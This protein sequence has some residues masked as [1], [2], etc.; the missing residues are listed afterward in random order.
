MKLRFVPLMAT[1]V[2]ISLLVVMPVV[3]AKASTQ[4]VPPNAALQVGKPD[5]HFG[6]TTSLNWAGYVVTS[7]SGAVTDVKGSWTV[8]SLVC[9]GGSTY[10]AFWVGIDGFTSNTVEQ[11]GVLAE[12]SHNSASYS[13]WYEFYPNPSVTISSMTVSAKDSISADV[14]YSS[15]TGQF[16]ITITDGSQTYSH[17]S[18]T[19]AA[20]NSAE[21]IVERPALCTAVVCRLTT[22]ANFGCA[23]FGNDA[24][25]IGGTTN[26]IDSFPTQDVQSLAMVDSSG[27]VLAQPSPLSLGGSFTV[28]YGASTATTTSS[29][30]SSTISSTSS[31]S[32]TT[33]SSTSTTTTTSSSTHGHGQ[34][35][36]KGH[37]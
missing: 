36:G 1:L 37:P 27:T 11:T 5:M 24:A 13:A 3:G 30:I 34:G 31:S 25:T 7:T 19:G 20:R 23:S 21:W 28:S 18:V 22:L 2:V 6:A 10:A 12:C 15:T 14:S 8:P 32:I 26:T 17:A 33:S 4:S 16:T 9:S 35:N 29:T